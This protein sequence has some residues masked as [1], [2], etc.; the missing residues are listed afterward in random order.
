M[1]EARHRSVLTNDFPGD[2]GDVAGAAPCVEHMHS[3]LGSGLQEHGFGVRLESARGEAGFVRRVER[4]RRFG[5][6]RAFG[7]AD[8]PIRYSD[9]GCLSTVFPLCARPSF[10]TTYR[11]FS[12]PRGT[13][14]FT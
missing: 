1:V 8:T 11:C 14:A 2:E 13:S 9:A 12:A 7:H 5:P 6:D 3:R 4:Q 10:S